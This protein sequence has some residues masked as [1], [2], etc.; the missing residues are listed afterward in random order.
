[1][2]EQTVG[3]TTTPAG[4]FADPTGT[5]R[6]WDGES[7]TEPAAPGGTVPASAAAG[8][9]LQPS[10]AGV[11]AFAIVAL[12]VGF[13]PYFGLLAILAGITA[14]DRIK[15]TGERGRLLAIVGMTFGAF[16]ALDLLLLIIRAAVS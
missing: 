6:W 13:L 14:L 11:N 2:D 10:R 12:L 3:P 15:L 9:P 8:V 5:M 4:W 1:M 7:W 16:W